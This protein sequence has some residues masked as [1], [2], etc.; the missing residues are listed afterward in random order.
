MITYFTN[1]YTTAVWLSRKWKHHA[2]P[3]RWAVDVYKGSFMNC[4]TREAALFRPKL[5][6]RPLS[7]RSFPRQ[8]FI[9]LC[10]TFSHH[11][12][13]IGCFEMFFRFLKC[14]M[15]PNSQISIF[16]RFLNKQIQVDSSST[17]IPSYLAENELQ[18]PHAIRHTRCIQLSCRRRYAK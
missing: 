2:I 11:A 6:P 9:P 1:H 4:V 8:Y 7:S 14:Q 10:V 5:T 13:K 3:R 15:L 18:S 17:S 12:T 16:L